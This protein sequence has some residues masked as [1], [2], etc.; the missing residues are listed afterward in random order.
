M[1]PRAR[2]GNV[3]NMNASCCSGLPQLGRL[4][5]LE[6]PRDAPDRAVLRVVMCLA[7]NRI[8]KHCGVLARRQLLRSGNKRLGDC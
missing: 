7:G 5:R 4:E 3:E 8:F 2:C 6:A 1:R